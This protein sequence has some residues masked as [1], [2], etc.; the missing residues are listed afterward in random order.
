M[1]IQTVVMAVGSRLTITLLSVCCLIWIS[2][3]C[4]FMSSRSSSSPSC[5][6]AVCFCR[7]SRLVAAFSSSCCFVCCCCCI[8]KSSP[9][10]YAC[11]V[12]SCNEDWWNS[13][14]WVT[15][16]QSYGGHAPLSPTARGIF[17]PCDDQ[18][19]VSIEILFVSTQ[20]NRAE[21]AYGKRSNSVVY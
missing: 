19:S 11:H 15:K 16:G 9:L 1:D 12:T 5:I 13:F 10:I 2:V 4:L 17:Q 21:K 7:W 20:H 8:R 18:S 6:L 3:T 14:Q